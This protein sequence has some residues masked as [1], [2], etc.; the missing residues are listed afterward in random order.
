MMMFE[1]RLS[2]ITQTM[3]IT[4]P[5]Q[6]RE[7]SLMRVG[8]VME[9]EGTEDNFW[10]SLCHAVPC[11]WLFQNLFVFDLSVLHAQKALASI[12]SCFKPKTQLLTQLLCISLPKFNQFPVAYFSIFKVLGLAVSSTLI[13]VLPQYLFFLFIFWSYFWVLEALFA[14]AS[15]HI[16]PIASID[17]GWVSS[18]LLG[19]HHYFVIVSHLSHCLSREVPLR[20]LFVKPI[21]HFTVSILLTD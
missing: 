15:V 20:T 3:E 8:G 2:W 14:L 4:W 1:I 7:R 12:S 17:F 18:Y 13:H 9:G 10:V 21:T 6:S 16:N 19:V 5:L 11:F